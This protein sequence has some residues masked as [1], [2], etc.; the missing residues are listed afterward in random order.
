M[1]RFLW[2]ISGALLVTACGAGASFNYRYYILKPSSYDGRLVGD[3][4]EHDLNLAVCAPESGKQAKCLV[5]LKDAFL[6]LKSDYLQLQ[7]Q[8]KE[9]QRGK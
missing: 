3:K 7:Q 9:C 8:L 6:Q 2:A 4:P 5:M 1:K